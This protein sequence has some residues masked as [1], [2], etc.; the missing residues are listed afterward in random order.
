MFLKC[1]VILPFDTIIV[2][3]YFWASK[4]V[5]H[6]ITFELYLKTFKLTDWKIGKPTA[7]F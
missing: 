1:T 5:S 6:V 7:Y 4:M 3:W 2:K